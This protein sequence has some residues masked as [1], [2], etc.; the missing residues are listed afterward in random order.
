MAN[1]RFEVHDLRQIIIRMRAGESDRD[2]AKAHLI[3]RAKAAELRRLAEEKRWLNADR[4]PLP[5][6]P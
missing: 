2:L 4:F 6:E 1:R 5:A 3:G